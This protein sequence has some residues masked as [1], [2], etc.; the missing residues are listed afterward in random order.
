MNVYISMVLFLLIG[1]FLFLALYDSGSTSTSL[2]TSTST[3]LSDDVVN[4][5]D[6]PN[7]KMNLGASGSLTTNTLTTTILTSPVTG[8]EEEPKKE[9][10]INAS[11][12]VNSGNVN[13]TGSNDAGLGVVKAN[14]FCIGEFCLDKDNFAALKRLK[15]FSSPVNSNWPCTEATPTLCAVNP[16]DDDE[17]NNCINTGSIAFTDEPGAGLEMKAPMIANAG[18]RGYNGRAYFNSGKVNC[19]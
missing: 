17:Y 16:D 2:S 8:T 3:S 19:S 18:I 10:K 9:I 14:K 11:L 12:T 4:D 7:I 13:V 5:D 6:S 1:L 15:M